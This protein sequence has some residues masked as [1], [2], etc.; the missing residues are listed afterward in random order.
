MDSNASTQEYGQNPEYVLQPDYQF[1]HNG[2]GLLQLACNFDV[3]I[4]RAGESA[5]I[6]RR[7]SALPNG[8]GPLSKAL[9]GGSTTWTLVKADEVGRDGNLA[10]VR[11]FYAAIEGGETTSQTEA[12]VTSAAV[13]ESIESHPNFSVHQ[14][15]TIGVNGETYNGSKVPLGGVFTNGSPPIIQSAADPKN[16]FRAYWYSQ[17]GNPGVFPWQFIGFLPSTDNNNVNR[18]AG[19]KS[20][21][22]P[23]ITMKLVAYTSD[24]Q[25]ATETGYSTGWIITQPS[26]G[27]FTIPEIYQNI[28]SQDPIKP[29]ELGPSK[30]WLVTGTNVEIYGGLYKVTADLLLSGVLG[31]DTDIYPSQDSS[32][33]G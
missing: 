11:A 4:S 18:K 13:S 8:G 9:A 19:V 33:V 12:T 25:K 5:T 15:P 2:Y 28:V 17:P 14:V 22:R 1:S 32:A 6:F 31:W 29:E 26:Y 3:D 24:A 30:N 27:V 10:R 16:P 20:W 7:G 21:F 23:A